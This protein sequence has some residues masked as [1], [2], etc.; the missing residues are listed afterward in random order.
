ME[1][2]LQSGTGRRARAARRAPASSRVLL[3]LSGQALAGG[4]RRPPA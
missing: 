2:E 4:G 3:K 1:G